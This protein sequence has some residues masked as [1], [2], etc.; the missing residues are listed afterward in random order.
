MHEAWVS[1]RRSPSFESAFSCLNMK[2]GWSLHQKLG[3]QNHHQQPD[4]LV[5][6]FKTTHQW[7][8]RGRSNNVYRYIGAKIGEHYCAHTQPLHWLQPDVN[9]RHISLHSDYNQVTP[10]SRCHWLRCGTE[11]MNWRLIV[12][13]FQIWS[14]QQIRHRV[15]SSPPLPRGSR[16]VQGECA[17]WWHV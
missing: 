11:L 9:K 3:L 6:I 2:Y 14:F 1:P 12:S 5:K 16:G 4:F 17:T 15:P 13:S 7:R 8:Q 10:S